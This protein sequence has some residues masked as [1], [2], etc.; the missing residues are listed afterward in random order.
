MKLDRAKYMLKGHEVVETT[1]LEEWANSYEMT[2]RR[3]G[4]DE[5]DKYSVSTVFLGLNHAFDDGPPMLFETMVFKQG[6]NTDVEMDRCSTW[7]EAEAM[8]AKFVEQYLGA[9]KRS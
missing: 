7:D 3:V 1:D 9:E 5:N 6:S 4:F 8:H 2:N